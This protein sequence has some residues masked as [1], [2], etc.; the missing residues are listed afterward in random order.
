M[1]IST[2]L[3]RVRMQLSVYGPVSGSAAMVRSLWSGVAHRLSA[4]SPG[5]GTNVYERDWDLL[6][7]LDA[8]RVDALEAV[9]DE[10]AFLPD[11]VPSL[12]SVAPNSELWLER[13]FTS[14]HERE[15]ACTTYVTAN[16]HA[17]G[18]Y[19]G[20]FEVDVGQF[21]TIDPVYEYGFD[22]SAGTIP[23]RPVTDAA[24][25]RFREDPPERGVVHYMQPHTPYRVLD[26]DGIGER[27]GKA[28]RETVWDWI[29][30]GRLSREEAWEYYLDNLRWVLDDVAVLLENVDADHV[31][32]SADHGEAFG[33]WGAYGHSAHGEFEGLRRVP[34]A[35]TTATDRETHEPEMAPAKEDSDDVDIEEQLEYLGY[36]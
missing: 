10:Y 7:L 34:W 33:E 18:F 36:R 2:W 20:S 13:T 30:A 35:R 19:D 4:L 1:T 29:A 22:E 28:F 16:G 32:V 26:L 21:R 11:T 9:A 14:E 17:D 27:D 5:G 25:R 6:V 23:P 15:I 24:I 3:N 31:I 8:C 12:R